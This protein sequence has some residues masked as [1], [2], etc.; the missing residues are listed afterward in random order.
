[1]RNK[2]YFL[3]LLLILPSACSKNNQPQTPQGPVDEIALKAVTINDPFWNPRIENNYR[4]SVMEMLT[5]YEEAGEAPDPK[6]V[7]AAGYILQTNS[8]PELQARID[9]G[10]P[11][12][13]DHVLPNGKPRAWKR[14]LNGEMYSAGHFMEAA[15]A[16]FTATGDRKM[17][18]VAIILADDIDANFGPGKRL[19]VSQHEEIKLGLLKLYHSTGDEKYMKLAASFIDQRG[20]SHNG[21]ELYGEYA[22]DHMPVAEQAEAVGHTVR[23]TYLY[24][25]L[26]ELA[27][28][29]KN[30]D[31]VAASD[32][33]WESAVYQKTY[34]TGNIGTYRDHEDFGEG[35]ELPN[36]SCWNETC[37]SIG[38]V[39]WNNQMFSLHRD[40]KYI[41]MLEKV[42]YNGFLSGVSLD[43]SEYFYQNPLRTYGN[44][45]RHEWFGPNCCPPNVARLI[46]SLGKYIY[47]TGGDNVYVNLFIGS[48]LTTE[49]DDSPVLISQETSYPWEGNVKITVSPE[50]KTDFTLLVRIPGWTGSEPIPGD[51]YSYLVN[52][53]SAVT[54]TLN[55][56]VL[57]APVEKGFFAVK[58]KWNKGDVLVLDM[59][60]KVRKVISNDK[61]L[62]NAGMVAL[63]RGP[64]VY[65]AEGVD[66][67]GKVL[68]LFIPDSAQFTGKFE[69]DLLGGVVK[70]TGNVESV[71][72]SEDGIS[73]VTGETVMTAVPWFAWANRGEGEMSVWMPRDQSKVVIPPAPSIA[74]ASTVTSSCGTG[75]LADNYP[76]GNVP[77][78]EIRFY[79]SAQ[80]GSVG[81][82]AL[83]DQLVPVNSFDG[84]STYL[85]L[86]PQTGDEAWVQYVFSKPAEISSSD[87]YW[88][89][90]KQYCMSPESWQLLYKSGGKWLPVKNL[91]PYTVEK[92]KYNTLTF[93][94]VMAVGLRLVIKLRGQEF[95]KG[96]L[97]PPDGNYMPD[98]T[99]W[100]ETGIIEWQV[101][102]K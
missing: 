62:D 42:L 25:P 47:A 69:P 83:Y 44:F 2:F 13:I 82:A 57:N 58:R 7:E 38:S 4:V 75:S 34:L 16:Y 10:I 91:T 19:D 46:A 24:T 102:G 63:E 17:L 45:E 59:P 52:D 37:A 18:D 9:K 51:L 90:D 72:R 20:H 36:L 101:S 73:T 85:S 3:A 99:T 54:L 97:G 100:Y 80:S 65:C 11:M 48:T 32:R 12:L 96:E 81:F 35:Y 6:L 56:K 26:A 28:I 8:D 1:M 29:T 67:N 84:S 95:K 92:D 71:S 43:G 89:D 41:D 40:A 98:D 87:I 5:K 61:V 31:Y 60:M 70:L 77:T 79:P 27:A 68:N 53:E 30:P 14:L 49:I 88:K 15:V 94:P 55:G 22:Q 76:G 50:E 93:E 23:A 66:N 86:R 78:T 21:R 74:S 39:F 33:L 64:L